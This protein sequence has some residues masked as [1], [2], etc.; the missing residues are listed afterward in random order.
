MS[1]A[2]GC[3]GS[4]YYSGVRSRRTTISCVGL[5]VFLA[6]A[7]ATAADA[8][9]IFPLLSKWSATLDDLPRFPP[10]YDAGFGYFSLRNDQLVAISLADGV[11]AWS[12]DC[13]TS[14]AP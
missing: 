8:A 10:A 1:K 6:I 5:A 13:P 7:G 11:A 9:L 4:R 3:L 14:V 12:V 2:R